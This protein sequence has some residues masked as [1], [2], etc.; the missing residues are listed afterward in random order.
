[1]GSWGTGISSN[2]TYADIYAEFFDLYNDGLGVKE[3]SD[4][5]ISSNRETINDSD[6]S[7]NFWFALAKAQW[8]CKQLD[9]DVLTKVTEIIQSGKD[10]EVW[11]SLEATESDIKKRAIVLDKFLKT[12]QT[13]KSKAKSRRKKIIR[14]PIFDKGDCLTFKLEN[15]NYGGAIVLEAI[16]DTEYG[17]NLLITTKINQSA[18]PSKKDFENA[19]IL[20]VN[21][22]AFE[23]KS[24]IHW[25]NPMRHKKIEHLIEV[26]DKVDVIESFTPAE[27]NFGY[28]A[29][30]DIW[31]I[32]MVNQEL[33]NP[34]SKTVR[35]IKNFIK[36]SK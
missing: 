14:Q 12:I 9:I 33:L 24:M 11:R 34:T 25:Y 22:G 27:T 7:N 15:G 2:D 21:R 32:G 31:I 3:I 36:T 26:I 29:D 20:V 4:R 30:F 28:V 8:E 17:L 10:L 13:E 6:D 23:D 1:M 35:S 16:R 18:K 19:E 5:L